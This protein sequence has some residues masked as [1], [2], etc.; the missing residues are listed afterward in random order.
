MAKK[1]KKRGQEFTSYQQTVIQKVNQNIEGILLN[2][3]AEIEGVLNKQGLPAEKVKNN[4]N[5]TKN[6]I[7]T[8]INNLQKDIKTIDPSNKKA[9]QKIKDLFNNLSNMVLNSEDKQNADVVG[10]INALLT[11]I[12]MGIEGKGTYKGDMGEAV[13]TVI[14]KRLMASA[15]LG[16]QN[17]VT[18]GTTG[19]SQRGIVSSSFSENID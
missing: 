19:R 1:S 17:V 5:R 12:S 3:V 2:T 18:T 4:I 14:A 13:T 7:Q 11:G 6:K 15:G 10:I 16:I 9:Q 8:F